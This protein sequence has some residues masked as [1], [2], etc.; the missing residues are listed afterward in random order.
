MFLMSNSLIQRKCFSVAPTLCPFPHLVL[1]NN[2]NRNNLVK[3]Y[4]HIFDM[5]QI[6]KIMTN[7]EATASRIDIEVGVNDGMFSN[8]YAV[9]LKLIDN[10]MVSFFVDRKLIK[11]EQ[12]KHFLNVTLVKRDSTSHSNLVL[13]PSETFETSSR[14]VEVPSK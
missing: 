3:L 13:L 5:S 4:A 2:R 12:G 8:E 10:S 14:W 11:T 1:I 7:K 6:K 9:S